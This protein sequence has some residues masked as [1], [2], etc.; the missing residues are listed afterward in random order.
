MSNNNKKYSSN[1]KNCNSSAINLFN[2][3]KDEKEYIKKDMNIHRS[4]A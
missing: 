2:S 1:N 3:M 4:N